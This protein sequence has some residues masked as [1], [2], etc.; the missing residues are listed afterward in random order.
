MKLEIAA[1]N[2]QSA[3]LAQSGGADRV[4]L[5]AGR[6]V[7]GT[8]PDPE[9]VRAARTSLNIPLFVMIRPRG[10]NF[11]YTDA[12]YEQMKKELLLLKGMNVNG[13]VF[14]L[15]TEDGRIDELKNK[16]LTGL[17]APL[18]CTFHRAFDE[19]AHALDALETIIGC[20]FQAI[21]TS[22]HQALAT[23]GIDELAMLVKRAAG[24]IRIMP[25]GGVRSSN[26]KMLAEKMK[27]AGADREGLYLH[28]SAII[29][30]SGVSNLKEVQSLKQ[31]MD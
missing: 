7:G 9:T 13:F 14:G 3:L 1:F 18:P 15:L 17:A 10:G 6:D 23:E 26:I 24:R 12:E 11:V 16:E 2:L 21:L 4:E 25:G 31:N 27:A 8:T 19:T 30:D 29:D 28:S 22:G 20:G 5:C